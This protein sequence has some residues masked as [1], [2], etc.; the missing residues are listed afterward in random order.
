MITIRKTPTEDYQRNLLGQPEFIL[1]SIETLSIIMA[2][3]IGI[4][5]NIIIH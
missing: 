5:F 2:I 4:W 1:A 3:G